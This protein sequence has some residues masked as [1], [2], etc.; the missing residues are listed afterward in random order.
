MARSVAADL[1]ER[2]VIGQC[3]LPGEA[4]AARRI[5]PGTT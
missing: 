3:V 5:G 4:H 2:V 1:A